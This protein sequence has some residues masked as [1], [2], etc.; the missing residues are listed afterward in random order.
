[1]PNQP[2]M[3]TTITPIDSSN[4]A[5]AKLLSGLINNNPNN[6]PVSPKVSNVNLLNGSRTLTNVL[7]GDANHDQLDQPSGLEILDEKVDDSQSVKSYN[8]DPNG[9][10]HIITKSG[11]S[12]IN[13][14]MLPTSPSQNVGPN[15]SVNSNSDE[16]VQGIKEA[17]SK[18]F[19][20]MLAAPKDFKEIKILQQNQQT[21]NSSHSQPSSP[22]N[23]LVNWL[24]KQIESK[25][26]VIENQT[27][28]LEKARLENERQKQELNDLKNSLL[29]YTT[30]CETLSN[31]EIEFTALEKKILGKI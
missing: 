25:D 22:N 9:E 18:N 13:G 2:T 26:K 30:K 10:I 6:N 31:G 19:M 16:L 3:V 17:D 1:M 14:N 15:D 27:A 7:A 4:E 21:S 20:S 24:R 8:S 5:L 28:E 11:E 29:I 23:D 12:T